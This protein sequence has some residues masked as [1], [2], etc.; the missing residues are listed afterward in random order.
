M[1]QLEEFA[2]EYFIQ[3]YS[4]T[5]HAKKIAVQLALSIASGV[6]F[7]IFVVLYFTASDSSICSIPLKDIYFYLIPIF[8]VL[9]I[10]STALMQNTRDKAILS[11]VSKDQKPN[12]KAIIQAKKKWISKRTGIPPHKMLE[13]AKRFEVCR[14]LSQ[15]NEDKLNHYFKNFSLR[16]YN[17]DAKPRILALSIS[18]ISVATLLLLRNDVHHQVILGLLDKQSFANFCLWV[19][20]IALGVFSVT[21]ATLIL[22]R[23]AMDRRWSFPG[24][25]KFMK[26]TPKRIIDIFIYD[27][28]Q[29]HT[30]EIHPTSNLNF[31]SRQKMVNS[32]KF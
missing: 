5:I 21:E 28:V 31:K 7:F 18:L 19:T 26:K 22:T 6:A 14:Q 4:Y 3:F 11:R 27:L 2:R 23:L 12:E 1:N 9:F 29:F 8:E 30:E 16:I 15:K 24:I 32:L 10:I 25:T 17:S 20:V 13:A